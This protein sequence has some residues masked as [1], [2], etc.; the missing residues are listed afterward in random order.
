MP[1]INR[2]QELKALNEKWRS[3]IAQFF[4]I[5]G[6]RRV[7]KTE[8]IKQFIKDKPAI[9]FLADKRTTADQLRELGQIV[10]NYF[11]DGILIKNGFGDWIEA[12]SYLKTKTADT[13]LVLAI[14]EYPYLTE[15]DKSTSSLFQKGWDEYLKNTKI[16]LILSG[17][18]IAMMESETL[19]QSAPLF[20]RRTGQILV[21]PLNFSQSRKFFPE[22]NFSDFL[23]IFTITGGM[24]AYLKQ[25]E[26]GGELSEEIKK[27]IFNKTAFLYNEVE[28]TLKEELR[29]TKNYLAILRAIA[30]GKRK[31]SEI[32]NE[33]GLD[34]ATANKYLSVLI[35]LRQVEREVPIT[36]DKPDKSR[37]GLYKISD[38]FFVFWF[39]YIFP[40]KS[41]LEMDNYDYV[42]EKMFS[43][44]KY[45]D[46]VNSDFK[47][48]TAQVYERV[49]V[50]LMIAWQDKIFAFERV[51]RYWNSN[52]EIDIVG[53]SSS[54]K[55]IIFGEC[56]WS[57][58]PVGTNIYEEL[59]KKAAKVEWKRGDRKE[60]Y[61]LFSKSGFTEEM[62]KIAK[63]DGVIL[64]EKDVVAA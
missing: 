36:E 44:L 53:F 4:I 63:S 17:S 38:N 14:D 40:Y 64:A 43:G 15:N 55:K 23:N 13:P 20:G 47:S 46:N 22:K 21:N 59:K 9:Y 28:F 26:G 33:V 18:S 57:E 12:F 56:K 2:E 60:Y 7:G 10:G 37:K 42:L 50:E 58:K 31:L 3:N 1:F 8:L 49:A 16:F 48:I 61:I 45:N 11:K 5:Y 39:Q 54:E 62:I 34:K 29:E 35:N 24:P 25:F 19:N 52:L 41:Y 51:G 30:L 27:K 32:V 6:K